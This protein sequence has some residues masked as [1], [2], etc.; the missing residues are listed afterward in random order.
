MRNKKPTIGVAAVMLPLFVLGGICLPSAAS[1]QLW[2]EYADIPNPSRG[3]IVFYADVVSLYGSE[4]E[5]IEEFYC[6]VPNDQIKF[7][8]KDGSYTGEL[9]YRAE[10]IDD[11]GDVIGA[12]E[13][14]VKVS[15]ADLDDTEDRSVVQIL[16]SKVT[17]PPGRYTARVTLEDLNAVKKELIAYLLKRYKKG[18]TEVLVDSKEF[19]KDPF[20]ISDI[21]FARGLRRTSIGQFQKS[22]FEII[23]NA[24]RRYGLLLPE[25]AVFFELYDFRESRDNDS[26]SASYAIINRMGG[27]IFRS[28]KALAMSG[29]R[30]ASTALFDVTS[31]AAGSYLL[32]LSVSDSQGEVLAMSER[33]FDVVWSPL[34]WGRYEFEMLGDMEYVLTEDEMDRFKALSLGE[35]EKFLVD[36]WKDIDPT[37]GTVENE[38]KTEHYRRVTYADRHFGVSA[39]RG[40][41]TDRGRLYVKYGPPDD[42]QSY[43]SDYEFV[44]GTRHIEGA[45]NPVPTDP[46]SRLGI[47][48]GSSEAGSW[49]QAGSDADVH[50]EQI[51][52]STVHGK[53]YEIW[54][55]DGAGLPVRRLSRRVPS[56]AGMRFI[57]VDER[58][59]GEYKLVYSTEKQE[60]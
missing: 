18:E 8:E 14:T 60:Y 15:A 59:F 39:T 2:V 7:V 20:S 10:I 32:A 6:V 21:E 34:S 1:S 42:M 25:L 16:Q 36:F 17:V 30:M 55:Y 43:Y 5:N 35:Q 38:A 51:G 58:G 23:P 40:A 48:T 54:R 47:K 52:G 26:L 24:Q 29:N 13:N 56:S 28:E 49:D 11:S 19:D 12:S 9:M 46:F 41:L 45:E 4:G 44:K 27:E 57:L 50:A 31:L 53:A 22:G 3:D 37:P 33:K